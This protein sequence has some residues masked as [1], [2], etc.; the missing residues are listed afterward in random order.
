MPGQSRLPRSITTQAAAAIAAST[1]GATA[2]KDD[3]A[4][5]RDT[6][7]DDESFYLSRLFGLPLL[8]DNPAPLSSLLGIPTLIT[9]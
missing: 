7:L 8:I 3:S 6:P 9:D 2:P 5:R 1:M 4:R